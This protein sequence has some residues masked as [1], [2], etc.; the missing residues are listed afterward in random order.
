MLEAGRGAIVNVPQPQ[1]HY[2]ASKA[3]MHHLTKSLAVGWAARRAC[4][5]RRADLYRD[6]TSRRI[7][8]AAG[9]GIALAGDDPAGRMSQP[10]E[11]ASVV[12]FLASD[13]SSPP[14]SAIINANAG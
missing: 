3:R 12:Q 14:N 6:A 13:A 5:R 9:R 4:E 1:C 8:D 10:H 7:E 11:I 2:N